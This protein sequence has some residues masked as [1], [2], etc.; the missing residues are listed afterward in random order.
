MSQIY[1]ESNVLGETTS[2]DLSFSIGGN[3]ATFDWANGNP[4]ELSPAIFHCTGSGQES[5]EFLKTQSGKK[6][7]E[8]IWVISAVS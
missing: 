1:S 8:N 7:V 3:G 5:G 2:S 4:L 6:C